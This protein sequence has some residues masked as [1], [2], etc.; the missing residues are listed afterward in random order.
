MDLRGVIFDVDGTL[1]DSERDGHRVAFNEAFAEF[2]LPYRWGVEEYGE[3]LRTTGGRQ[4]LEGYLLKQG[5][6][7]D[8]AADLAVR[9]HRRKTDLFT[10]L[11]ES[12]AIG[13][14][15]GVADFIDDLKAHGVPR[16][17]AT[18]GT[19]Q[20]VRA[21][22]A[23]HFTHDTFDVVVTGEDVETL[24]PAPDAYLEVL[25]R[26]DAGPTGF[27]AIEDSLNGLQ[28]AQ[29]AGLP[30]VMVPNEYT[31]GDITAA[32]LVVSTLGPDA[33]STATLQAI[34]QAA[35]QTA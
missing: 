25:R 35:D 27:V 1:V 15:P 6:D 7:A 29:A 26:L 11:V 5:L 8:E 33:M 22:L 10:D 19:R 4:R 17:V 14:R 32:E 30:C 16:H 31:H 13:L 9:L 23:Q 34:A 3:L 12:G 24:K 28:A 21:V 18:T 20:W 2:D